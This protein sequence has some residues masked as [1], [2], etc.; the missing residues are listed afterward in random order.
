MTGPVSTLQGGMQETILQTCM[1]R[2]AFEKALTDGL[3]TKASRGG[4]PHI[5]TLQSI[6]INYKA[7]VSVPGYYRVR[8]LVT[9]VTK[10]GNNVIY[11]M[12]SSIEA[13]VDDKWTVLATGKSRRLFKR[14]V[15]AALLYPRRHTG[16]Q[17][18]V[19]RPKWNEVEV[20]LEGPG[21][22]LVFD[23]D[24]ERKP[25][26]VKQ[27]AGGFPWLTVFGPGRISKMTAIYEK[28]TSEMKGGIFLDHGVEGAE[29]GGGFAS[30][31]ALYSILDYLL[32]ETSRQYLTA[33]G[34][35]EPYS[36][37]ANMRLDIIEL[38]R[39]PC[40]LSYTCKMVKM[41]GRKLFL[42][43][44]ARDKPGGKIHVK[45]EALFI[46]VPPPQKM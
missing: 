42:G 19:E 36:V 16:K 21:K 13:N 26:W 34:V 2:A 37:T 39:V 30:P 44:E 11:D 35:A 31:D 41:E 14:P 15:P 32:V 22:H 4:P 6:E 23:A 27:G 46:V 24:V 28:S 12:E 29:N 25:G 20:L 33:S 43:V 5:G 9:S 40:M 38:P 10:D 17:T 3:A 18:R 7:R 45:G 1:A 8:G